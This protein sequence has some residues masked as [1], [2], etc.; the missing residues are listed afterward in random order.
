MPLAASLA[1]LAT[2]HLLN[3]F[4]PTWVLPALLVAVLVASFVSSRFPFLLALALLFF[5]W[6]QLSLQPL[7]RPRPGL[8]RFASDRPV[9]IEGVLDCRPEP[10][11]TG[12]SRV[13]LQ[14]EGVSVAG[15]EQ[16]ASGRLLVYVKEGRAELSTGDRIRFASRIR[17]PR[18]L[19]L[20]GESDSVRRL[21]Y[22][23]VYATGF[24]LAAEDLVLLRPGAGWLHDIDLLAARLGNFIT[25]VEPWTEGGVLKAL[26]LGDRRDVPE[27]L[28]EAFARCGVNH[29]LSISGFHVGILFLSL[30]QFLYYLA[31][32]SEWLALHLKLRPLVMLASLPMVVFYLVLSGQAPATLRSVLMICIVVAALRLKREVDLVHTIMLA[33]CAMLFCA[34]QTAFDVSFQLSFLAIWG[35]SVLTPTLAHPEN[36]AGRVVWWLLLLFIASVAAILATSVHVAYYFQRIALVGLVANLLVVPL[37]GYGAVVLGFS[38][39]VVSCLWERPAAVL[40]HLAAALV[41]WSDRVVEQL[42]RAPVITGYIP[43]R[44]DLLLACLVLCAITFFKSKRWR[45]AIG[46]PLMVVLVLRAVPPA[47]ATEGTLRLSFLSVGQGDAT[48]VHLPDGKWMLVDGGG[49]A[50]DSGTPVGSRLLLP[51][52]RALSARR[53]DYLVLSHGHP[54]HLQGVLYLAANYEVG[55]FLVHPLTLA[56]PELQQLKWVLAARDVP[57][58]E[59]GAEKAPLQVGGVQLQTLWPVA[60]TAL[61]AD[62]NAASLVFRLTY[63]RTSVLF[64]GDIGVRE[65]QELLERG[66]L[67]RCSLLKVAH[68]GSR[69]SSCEPFIAAVQPTAAV[70]S[71]GYRNAFHLPAPATLYRLQR[72][73]VRICRTDLEGTVEADCKADGVVILSTPWGHFN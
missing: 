23:Q 14:V 53:I 69:Y 52:L 66:G 46:I 61:Q 5:A 55:Q 48:L 43:D 72:H 42:S 1:G 65:E 54:D 25:R 50:T 62:A 13:Y 38:A 35:L 15:Q 70:I 45:A 33:A 11:M 34:P 56:S 22:Q 31:R 30:C 8:E 73:G 58:R 6:G 7:L 60:G 59:L 26:L 9:A 71:A 32:R 27:Q 4:P 29:I 67:R 37:M 57:V 28:Q 36:K 51:A 44:L 24:V 16:R 39:L 40:L 63:G 20:P 19:G 3:T 2:T 64:T 17:V 47:R 49:N 18:N 21:A 10:T 41:R 12:G 68:H